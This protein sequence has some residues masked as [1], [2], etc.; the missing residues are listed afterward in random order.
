MANGVIR[1]GLVGAGANTRLRHIPG[2]REQKGV[3]IVGVANRSR[4]SGERIAGEY[5]IPKVYDNWLELMEDD[6]IDAVCVGTWPYMHRNLVIS[7]LECGKHVLTEARM[8]MNAQEAH[9][10]LDASRQFPHL[11]TQIVPAPQTLQVD[12]TIQEQIAKGYLGDILAV[13]LRVSDYHGRSNRADTFLALKIDPVAGVNWRRRKIAPQ[14]FLPM[15]F[16][17]SRIDT[18]G[19]ASV[20]YHVDRIFDQ[21]HRGSVR[22][23]LTQGPG[24]VC[25]G[26]ITPSVGANS[27]HLWRIETRADKNEAVTVDRPRNH[28]VTV[29]FRTPDLL[30]VG[31]IEGTNPVAAGTNDHGLVVNHDLQQCAK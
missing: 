17:G 14:A 16:T 27:E 2:I 12:A 8:A 26:N 25:V 22:R 4:E 1:V 11:V 10:M 9:D 24:N 28:A 29:I 20:R 21:Q 7:A 6:S 15:D 18:T 3:E 13:R 30:T 31:G 5:E 23:A 19:N